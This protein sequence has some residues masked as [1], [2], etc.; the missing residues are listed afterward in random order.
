MIKIGN[1]QIEDFDNTKSLIEILRKNQIYIDAPCNATGKCG[2]CKIMVSGDLSEITNVELDLL[3]AQEINNNVRL[4][5][6][7]KCNTHCDIKLEKQDGAVIETSSTSNSVKLNPNI[8]VINIQAEKPSIQNQIDDETAVINASND[9]A[10]KFEINAIPSL[11]KQLRQNNFNISAVVR[12]KSIIAIDK[13]AF[14]IAV[15]IGTTTVVAY[16][17]DLLR[18]KLVS[19]QSGINKQRIFGADVISRISSAEDENNL[20]SLQHII[21]NQINDFINN[22]GID[23]NSIYQVA[24][25][26]N[27]TMLHL[28]CGVSPKNIADAPF[29]PATTFGFNIKAT[30]IGISANKNAEIYLGKC[31]SAY[32]G[33]D[34]TLGMLTVD[35]DISNENCVFIDVGT[36]GEIALALN[37]QISVCSTA[38][39]PA[40]E[41]AHIKYGM[42]GIDGAISS[43][44]IVDGDIIT[45]TIGNKKATGICG[46]GLVDAIAVMLR[47]GVIDETGRIDTDVLP[48][49]IIYDDDE[50]EFLIDKENKIFITQKDI[51]QI[52]LAKAA[53]AAGINTLLNTKNISYID[54]DTFYVAGGFGSFINAKNA[55]EIGLF[56]KQLLNKIKVVGNAAGKGATNALLNKEYIMRAQKLFE[57]SK[58]IELSGNSFFQDEY[59]EQM[60]F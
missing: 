27:T 17:Y 44:E 51:R 49:R 36:N 28:L 58:Y 30:E 35:M 7:T 56:P 60:M 14:G 48:E 9:N 38:A 2:K 50:I 16:F 23:S 39:G 15:D 42:G 10:I 40:F 34:I 3:S 8:K 5:C 25:A 21:V 4:A 47:L 59:I 6:M 26:A 33:G 32:V 41:G 29:I 53:I 57:K 46:S 31:I 22:S 11:P 55:C 1:I 37:N 20:K 45:K 13:N 19:V 54:I 12:D 43:V 24:I 52:Q 18:G